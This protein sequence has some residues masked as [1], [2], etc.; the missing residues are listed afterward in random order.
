MKVSLFTLPASTRSDV[1]R[2]GQCKVLADN[3]TAFVCGW[4]ENL[5]A[6][7]DAVQRVANS[8]PLGDLR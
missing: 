5:V 6:A 1:R 8:D 3:D 4:H 7:P 2:C